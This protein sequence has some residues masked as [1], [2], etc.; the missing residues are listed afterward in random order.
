MKFSFLQALPMLLAEKIASGTDGRPMEAA[1]V[2]LKNPPRPVGLNCG[3]FY[4]AFFRRNTE[5][6][7]RGQSIKERSG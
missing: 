1:P 2:S 4:R 7:E 5:R 6:A 3:G